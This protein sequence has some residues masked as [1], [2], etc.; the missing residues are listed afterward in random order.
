MELL[1]YTAKVGRRAAWDFPKVVG[2]LSGYQCSLGYYQAQLWII[3]GTAAVDVLL[4]VHRT[5]T[6]TSHPSLPNQGLED[7]PGV[8]YATIPASMSNQV[9][10]GKPTAPCY[11]V[12]T[13]LEVGSMVRCLL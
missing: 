10:S 8:K 13:K 1:W 9:L 5:C 6:D 7:T 3:A 4:C 11:S 12:G 2:F